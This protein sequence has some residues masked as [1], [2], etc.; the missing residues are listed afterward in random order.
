MKSRRN[1]KLGSLM[2][3]LSRF[4]G[5]VSAATPD[6]KTPAQEGVCDVLTADGVTKDLFGFCVTI[7]EAQDFAEVS[8]PITE[9]DIDLFF[10]KAP[11][12]KIIAQYDK[13]RA[14]E[15]PAMPRIVP[16]EVSAHCSILKTKR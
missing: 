5:S 4:G 3:T 11:S 6:G 10:A 1:T 12:G 13:P 7:C 15:D 2:R 8:S 14:V 9:E 16:Q